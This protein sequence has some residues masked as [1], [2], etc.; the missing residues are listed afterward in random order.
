MP[1]ARLS[2]TIVERSSTVLSSR[3]W[4][5]RPR[6][7]FHDCG[8]MSNSKESSYK[9][10]AAWRTKYFTGRRNLLPGL[11]GFDISNRGGNPPNGDRCVDLLKKI[12][13]RYD[14]QEGDHQSVCV[15]E[16][17]GTG[18]VQR[19]NT[20]ALEGDPLLTSSIEGMNA[21]YGSLS[22]SHLNQLLKNI[23]GKVI[24][25][26]PEITDKEG[27]LS[28]SLLAEVDEKMLPRARRACNGRRS[29][30]SSGKRTARAKSSNP[31]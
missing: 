2:S 9:K 19:F 31:H 13:G 14:P 26:I 1:G 3:L 28:L 25:D 27:R 5:D 8:S 4:N 6:R 30:S 22:H 17:P 12:L 11:V 16:T 20:Q 18:E 21:C 29:P 23:L 10:A 15:E 7:C 24:M